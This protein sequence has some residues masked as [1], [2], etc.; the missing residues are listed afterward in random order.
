MSTPLAIGAVSAALR[1]LVEIGITD[2]NLAGAVGALVTVSTIAPDLIDLDDPNEP[3]R[4]NLFLVQATPNPGWRNAAL[5]SHD[6][7]GRR[8]SNPPLALDLQYL[9]TA[10]GR[11]DAV[12]EMLLG[13]A[14]H[15]LH[16]HPRLSAAALADLLDPAALPA[17]LLALADSGLAE[18]AEV[19]K[20]TP[21]TM[22]TDEWS[23]IWSALQ[24]HYR[25]SASYAVS[26]VLIENTRPTVFPLPVLTR[27]LPD[28][29][30]GRDR[31]VVVQPDL[32]PPFP[33]LLEVEPIQRRNVAL[34][35]EAVTLRGVRLAGTTPSV[36]L[37]H[38][39][40]PQAIDL[41]VALAVDG[42]SASFT[43]PNTGPDQVRFVPGVWQ[44]TLRV[45][46]PGEAFVRESNAVALLIAPAPVIAADA[47]LGLPAASLVR[48]GVPEQL[49]LTLRTRPQVR[50]EQTVS[51]ML[52]GEGATAAAR[53]N[54]ADPLVFRFAG[55]AVPA[56]LRWL[57]L[58]VDGVE[59]PLVRKDGPVPVFD[60][61]YRVNVP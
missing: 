2:A 41:P 21:T 14:M 57:R 38:R 40:A 35:G 31:G 60:P 56:G 15:I 24:T 42:R 27:G 28:P 26:V 25:P 5:P 9:V 20:I 29:A 36:R 33:T 30:T 4:I 58:R 6:A 22:S 52:D 10:Y 51:A 16:E 3:P 47:P 13:H 39:L 8:Q 54:G 44:L 48:G 17:S 23:K 46:P 59:S 37:T 1:S 45:Q 18:Q 32:L 12:A 34:L 43:L 50:P 49:T 19:L 61:A 11:G 55:P 53:A 7:G